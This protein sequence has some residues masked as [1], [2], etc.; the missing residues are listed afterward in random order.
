MSKSAYMRSN[1]SVVTWGSPAM[2]GNCDVVRDQ[3]ASGVQ[4]IAG[5]DSASAAIRDGSV[6]ATATRLASGVQQIAGTGGASAG[7]ER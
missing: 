3:L 2:G 4:Q 5:H 6:V 1:G 7:I